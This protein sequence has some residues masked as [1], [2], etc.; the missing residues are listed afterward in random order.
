[1]KYVLWSVGSVTYLLVLRRMAEYLYPLALAEILTLNRGSLD[2]SY[3]QTTV[4]HIRSSSARAAISSLLRNHTIPI[5]EHT[6]E[7]EH[8]HPS[9]Q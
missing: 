7:I 8:T 6:C 2:L 5:S 4:S 9:S 1:M 3:Q